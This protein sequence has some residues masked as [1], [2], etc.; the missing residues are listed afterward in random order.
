MAYLAVVFCFFCKFAKK[1]NNE[2]RTL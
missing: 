1:Q 2:F